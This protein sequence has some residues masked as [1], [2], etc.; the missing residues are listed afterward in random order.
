MTENGWIRDRRLLADIGTLLT[1]GFWKANTIKLPF[2][3]PRRVAMTGLAD[4]GKT[5]LGENRL[6]IIYRRD[7]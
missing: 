5:T 6:H 2:R 7:Q 1:V 3:K 4:N